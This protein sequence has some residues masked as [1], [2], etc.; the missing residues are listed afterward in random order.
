M[1]LVIENLSQGSYEGEFYIGNSRKSSSIVLIIRKNRV[2][3]NSSKLFNRDNKKVTIKWHQRILET[4]QQ[5]QHLRIFE[6][7]NFKSKKFRFWR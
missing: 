2:T 5:E 4:D 7:N 6:N 1:K 3:M